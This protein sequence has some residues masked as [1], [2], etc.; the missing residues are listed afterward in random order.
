MSIYGEGNGG[1]GEEEGRRGVEEGGM[2]EDGEEGGGKMGEG[3]WRDVCKKDDEKEV[4]DGKEEGRDM[5]EWDGERGG[6][7]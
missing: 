7:G 2:R 5:E 4:W 6:V 1:K 3:G